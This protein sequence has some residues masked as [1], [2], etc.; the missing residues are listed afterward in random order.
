MGISRAIEGAVAQVHLFLSTC[1]DNCPRGTLSRLCPNV[2]VLRRVVSTIALMLQ[3]ARPLSTAVG[4]IAGNPCNK[5][6]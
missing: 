5:P 1:G 2:E 3:E 6:L 4:H